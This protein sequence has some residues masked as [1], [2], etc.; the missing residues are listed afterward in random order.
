MSQPEPFGYFKAEPFAWTDCGE[1]EEGATALYDLAGLQEAILAERKACADLCLMLSIEYAKQADDEPA[2]NN[3]IRLVGAT[4]G[5]EA[6]LQAIEAR[7]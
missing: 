3:I 2:V 4:F 7:E 6:C 5:A 1:D